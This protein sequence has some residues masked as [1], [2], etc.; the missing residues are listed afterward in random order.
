MSE[1]KLIQ[2]KE[3]EAGKPCSHHAKQFVVDLYNDPNWKM[4][5]VDV[6]KIQFTCIVCQSKRVYKILPEKVIL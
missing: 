3:A 2:H 1:Y 6:D 5:A 4:E